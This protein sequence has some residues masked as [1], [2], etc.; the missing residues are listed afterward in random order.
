MRLRGKCEGCYFGDKCRR[1]GGCN[2]YAP[3]EPEPTD[4]IDELISDMKKEFSR[5]WYTYIN[6]YSDYE[7]SV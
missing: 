4:Y 5:E 2:D 1:Q 7:C 6:E 3:L